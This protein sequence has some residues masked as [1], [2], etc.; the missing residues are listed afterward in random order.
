LYKISLGGILADDMGLGKTIQVIGFL[1]VLRYRNI[2]DFQ[3]IVV[4]TS[5]VYNWISE[6]K[7]F[8]PL[9]NVSV[10]ESKNKNVYHESWSAVPPHIVIITYGLLTENVEL[11]KQYKWNSVIYDEAQN[12]KNI[13]S[14]RT[15]AARSLSAKSVFCITGTPMEN[16]FGEYF[17]LID[18]CV[19]GALGD[20]GDFRQV[21]SLETFEKKKLQEEINYLRVKT[22][23]LVLRRIK[24]EMLE[25]LPDKFESTIL[26]PFEKEQLKI[27]R[28]IAIS[29]NEKIKSVIDKDNQTNTQLEMLTALLRLRQVCSNPAMIEDVLYK[30]NPPKFELLLESVSEIYEKGESVL[31]FTNFL[32][33]LF[34]LEKRFKESGYKTHVIHGALSAKKRQIELDQFQNNPEASILIMTLK[35]G[36]VGLN[37]TKASYV[38][39]IEPWWNPAAENQATD[40]AHRIGQKKSV[41]V[42]KYIM[43]DSIEEKIQ[44]LKVKKNNAFDALFT[45]ESES[46]LAKEKS[47]S[48]KLSYSDFEFLIN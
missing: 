30:K 24:S 37:L 33:T 36:G 48:G 31:I 18:L 17:S 23:P 42:Y 1:E 26:L 28:D 47:F 34:E 15:T 41:Q 22:S 25:Q 46:E 39:H 43:K 19:P 21:F 12:L 27:Y 44:E 38:F 2:T 16:H 5:L 11:L 7:K 29:W 8:A 45:E 20:Y 35:T 9:L 10:F 3:L 6:I 32:A 13:T 14:Q 40:R 4:P